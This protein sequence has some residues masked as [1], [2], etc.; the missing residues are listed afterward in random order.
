MSIWTA[1]G[2]Y[3]KTQAFLFCLVVITRPAHFTFLD[4]IAVAVLGEVQIMKPLVMHSL[5][6]LLTFS[7]F[8]TNILRA[9]PSSHIASHTILS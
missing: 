5:Q 4:F 2:S 3:T 7:Q 1:A 8:R 6:R 9:T